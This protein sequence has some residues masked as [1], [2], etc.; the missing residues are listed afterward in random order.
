[1]GVDETWRVDRYT[2]GLPSSA[3]SQAGVNRPGVAISSHAVTW[4]LVHLSSTLK[5]F[6]WQIHSIPGKFLSLSCHKYDPNSCFTLF[7]ST[8]YAVTN[9]WIIIRIT[10]VL[11]LAIINNLQTAYPILRKYLHWNYWKLG[12]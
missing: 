1:M 9:I 11:V 12:N 4:H 8:V 7:Q 6:Q 3:F 5:I 10:L 2:T